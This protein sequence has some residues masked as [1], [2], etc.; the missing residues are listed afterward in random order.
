MADEKATTKE[1]EGALNE[2]SEAVIKA[3]DGKNKAQEK[4][5]ETKKLDDV[6]DTPENKAAIAEA[7]GKPVEVNTEV[8]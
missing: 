8:K 4:A 6:K 2:A 3:V 5:K 1:L 7:E